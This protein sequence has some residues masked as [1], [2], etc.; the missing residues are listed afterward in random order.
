MLLTKL[1][2]NKVKTLILLIVFICLGVV[3]FGYTNDTIT[4]TTNTTVE[5]IEKSTLTE[6]IS[7]VSQVL[8]LINWVFYIILIGCASVLNEAIEAENCAVQL[9]FMKKIP[10][11]ARTLFLGIFF[12]FLFIWAYSIK[13][14]MSIFSLIITIFACMISLS[15]GL[16]KIIRFISER[17]GLR[18]LR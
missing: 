4:Q 5:N 10:R 3:L 18:F 11:G 12:L 2:N 16:N 1:I 13:D 15:I 8:Q 17:F 6:M 9:N 7:A 14:R